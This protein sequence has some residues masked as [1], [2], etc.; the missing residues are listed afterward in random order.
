MVFRSVSQRSFG[1]QP[2]FVMALVVSLAA[3]VLTASITSMVQAQIEPDKGAALSVRRA[4]CDCSL[5]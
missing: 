5:G 3:L 4:A 1:T 2:A